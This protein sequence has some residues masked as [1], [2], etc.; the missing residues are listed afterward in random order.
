MKMRYNLLCKQRGTFL[1]DAIC[2]RP[3]IFKSKKSI[4][5]FLIEYH[6][7]FLEE[8]EEMKEKMLAMTP[9]EICMAFDWEIIKLE[10]LKSY[11]ENKK[12][13][14]TPKILNEFIEITT[15]SGDYV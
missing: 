8:E 7:D 6:Y 11:D 2:E 14:I 10:K 13:L 1:E 15:A 12:Y 3:A 5:E 4:K 9:D